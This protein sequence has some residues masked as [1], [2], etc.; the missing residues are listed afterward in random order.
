MA[1]NKRSQLFTITAIVLIGAGL[2]WIVRQQFFD[3]EAAPEPGGENLITLTGENH[4]SITKEGI[5]LIDFWA[6]WCQPCR[7]QGPIVEEVA[8]DMG[9]QATIAKLDI[10]NYRNLAAKYKIQ[11]IPT[12]VI[13][14]NGKEVEKFVGVQQK[15]I[16]I[17][18]IQKYLDS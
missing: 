1:N 11:V 10:D 15:E 13:L 14:K 5:V 18:T 4:E 7:I 12:I 17:K 3:N 16:L 9:N 2:A 8:E 6:E